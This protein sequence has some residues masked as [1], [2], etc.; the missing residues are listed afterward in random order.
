MERLIAFLLGIALTQSAVAECMAT[1]YRAG[2]PIPTY[3]VLGTQTLEG[4]WSRYKAQ[5]AESAQ[6]TYIA[7]AEFAVRPLLE[8]CLVELAQIDEHGQIKAA[9]REKLI[10]QRSCEEVRSGD[11]HRLIVCTSRDPI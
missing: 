7:S 2:D 9:E 11:V 10:L 5:Y 4:E 6:L 3:I 8:Q 1:A